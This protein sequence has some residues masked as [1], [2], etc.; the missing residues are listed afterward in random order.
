MFS[1]SSELADQL[2]V[3]NSSFFLKDYFTKS[4][5]E[6]SS[7]VLVFC[8]CEQILFKGFPGN[9]DALMSLKAGAMETGSSGRWATEWEDCAKPLITQAKSVG[10]LCIPHTYF[11][12]GLFLIRCL[13]VW[14]MQVVSQIAD[15]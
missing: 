13:Y 15:S 12:I 14:S 6:D 1:S 10:P 3:S 11:F 8:L 7:N 9:C 5:A 4:T 2:L